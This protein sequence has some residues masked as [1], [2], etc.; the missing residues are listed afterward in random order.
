MCGLQE[1]LL[2][3]NKANFL[4]FGWCMYYS[5]GIFFPKGTFFTQILFL[6]LMVIS[7]YHLYIANTRFKLPIYFFGLNLLVVMFSVYG[8]FFMIDGHDVVDYSIKVSNFSY[9]KSIWISLL[10]IYSFYVLTKEKL[11]TKR[12]LFVW[13]F[14]FLILGIGQYYKI[15]QEVLLMKALVG[16]DVEITNNSGYYFLSLIPACVYLRKYQILQFLMIGVCM[17]FLLMAMKRGALIVGVLCAVY[18]FWISFKSVSIKRKAFVIILFTLVCGV[19]GFVVQDKMENSFYFQKRVE[20]TLNGNSSH[21]DELYMTFLDYFWNETNPLNF[22][23][24]SGANATLTVSYNYA[25]NDWLEIAVNQ[26]IVGIMIYFLY[27]FLFAKNAIENKMNK[28]SRLAVQLL[29]IIYFFKA[30]VSTSYMGMSICASCVLGF[31]L[32]QENDDEQIFNC[33]KIV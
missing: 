1:M 23:F 15:E 19:C 17:V 26:G 12:I 3:V 5:Q 21:R 10:P 13:I 4:L 31:S 2:G 29:W 8:I 11:F 28:H 9:V 30:L 20:D 25:H 18:F 6:A 22:I 14:F 27:W 33:N 32:A 16:M 7:F 24:G